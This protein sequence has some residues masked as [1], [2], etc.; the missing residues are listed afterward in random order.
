METFDV[1]VLGA[2]SAGVSAALRASDQ[3]AQVCIIE[4][5]RIGGS[6][7]HK[8]VYPL[9]LG[10]GLLRNN[11]SNFNVNGRIDSEKL[12][13]N[14]TDS[15]RSLSHRW[16]QRLIGSGVTIKTGRGLPF[17]PA[18]VQV[19]SNEKTFDVGAKKIIIATGSSPVPLSTLPYETDIIIPT[20][21]IFKNH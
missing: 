8:G 18:L 21:D 12:F 11:E 15:M 5:E 19:R 10:L 13:R 4:Q 16:E 14:I 20:D 3:G 6:C 7:I 2:G 9:K 1:I 17:S